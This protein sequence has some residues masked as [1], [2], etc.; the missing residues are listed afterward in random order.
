M[1]LSFTGQIAA[2]DVNI[3]LTFPGTNTITLND[4]AVRNLAA[5][6]L[7]PF[8]ASTV[9]ANIIFFANTCSFSGASAIDANNKLLVWGSYFGINEPR[10]T[11][12]SPIQIGN[13]NW[14]KIQMAYHTSYMGIKSDGTLWAWGD[15][16]N[17]RLGLNTG[18]TFSSPVQVGTKNTWTDVVGNYDGF[19]L[20]ESSNTVYGTGII[21]DFTSGTVHRSSPVFLGYANT[22]FINGGHRG[23]SGAYEL[24]EYDSDGL[25]KQTLKSDESTSFA[26][27]RAG[28]A[29]FTNWLLNDCRGNTHSLLVKKQDDQ[30]RAFIYGTGGDGQLGNSSVFSTTTGLRTNIEYVPSYDG[31]ACY[32]VGYDHTL[33]Q[34]IVL[35]TRTAGNVALYVTGNNNFGQLGTNSTANSNSFVNVGT[36]TA[37]TTSTGKILTRYKK[38]TAGNKTSFGIL[39]GDGFQNYDDGKLFAWGLNNYGQLGSNNTVNYSSPVQI[40]TDRWKTITTY[41]ESSAAIKVDGSLWTF[42]RNN[43]G[44]LGINDTVDYSSPVQIGTY[45]W[46]KVKAG[47]DFFIAKK[48]NGTLWVWGNNSKGQLGLNDTVNR[49]SPVQLS[50]ANSVIDF[51]ATKDAIAYIIAA[52]VEISRA[53][54]ELYACGGND[55]GQLGEND[56]VYRSSPTLVGS[57]SRFLKLYNANYD[58]G[59]YCLLRAGGS[60]QPNTFY[61]T[62]LYAWGNNNQNQLGNYKDFNYVTNSSRSSPTFI[63]NLRMKK[64]KEVPLESIRT[65]AQALRY[66]DEHDF[67]WFKQEELGLLP[68]STHSGALLFPTVGSSRK[69]SYGNWKK[70][71]THAYFSLA[72]D[73]WGNLFGSGYNYNGVLTTEYGA[74]NTLRSQPCQIGPA[75]TTRTWSDIQVDKHIDGPRAFALTNEG[76]LYTWG[77]NTHG[78]LGINS[79]V[80]RSNPTLVGNTS[81]RWLKAVPGTTSAG[82][83]TDGTLWTWAYNGSGTLGLN[84]LVHRSS[85]VQIGSNTWIDI[86]VANQTALGLAQQHMLGVQSNGT[87]WSWGYGF[88]GA[89]GTNDI[90]NRSSPVQIG[91]DTNWW[92][93]FS[94]GLSSY[95]TKI[96]GTLWAWGYNTESQLGIGVV[97]HRSSPVQIGFS[98]TDK[99]IDLSSSLIGCHAI[100]QSG[101][102]WVW[103]TNYNTFLNPYAAANIVYS[104]PVLISTGSDPNNVKNAAFIDSGISGSATSNAFLIDNSGT[105]F[106]WGYNAYGAL[107]D[108][109][110]LTTKTIG[111]VLFTKYFLTDGQMFV[112]HS[113][114]LDTHLK[115][116]INEWQDGVQDFTTYYP[117]FSTSS[118]ASFYVLLNG[119]NITP[120][121]GIERFLYWG[122]SLKNATSVLPSVSRSSPVVV[123]SGAGTKNILQIEGQVVGITDT[124][125]VHFVRS[126]NSGGAGILEAWGDGTS[127]N[128][129]NFDFT[130]RS[131]PVSVS[132][133]TTVL[134]SGAFQIPAFRTNQSVISMDDLRGRGSR[135]VQV[136]L[137]I[138]AGTFNGTP[139]GVPG[140]WIGYDL[141]TNRGPKYDA[142]NTEITLTVEKGQ[143][144]GTGAVGI[145]DG[146]ITVPS[147]FHPKDKIKIVNYGYIVGQ[148]GTGGNPSPGVTADR[149]G[150]PGRGALL[151]QRPVIIDNQGTIAGGGG[152]GG[153]G[154]PYPFV[155]PRPAKQGGPLTQT[156][157]GGGGGGGAG[158]VAGAGSGFPAATPGTLT[159]GG[160]GIPGPQTSPTSPANNGGPGGSLG[161]A[162]SFA[163]PTGGIGGS[164]GYYIQGLPFVYWANTGTRLGPSS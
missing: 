41:N 100:T 34:G 156:L 23:E 17:G 85:P 160:A 4:T 115:I 162:G 144:V 62:D 28:G 141:Y 35:S 96:D 70:V 143:I 149:L 154:S 90:V 129:G 19:I 131:S 164:A 142:G 12:V 14:S 73:N 103:G 24:I 50:V 88:H 76:N 44:Q 61:Y 104:S 54:T 101:N 106:A 150:I 125:S 99:V 65:S 69:N 6:P 136:Q 110:A 42:G 89:L 137:T 161:N 45:G 47:L 52:N 108:N 91:T 27:K 66:I 87:L 159:I 112:N 30:G 102:V 139:T 31:D 114:Y 43:N 117:F 25:I 127:G 119:T 86:A 157:S 98:A 80:T 158:S 40:G 29:L 97:G 147:A 138:P 72:I 130:S 18:T 124:G 83:R 140:P 109:T 148:G 60:F 78:N 113:G 59:F 126:T 81:T 55:Y 93:V 135:A 95:A 58:G 79:I 53:N 82:I 3:E 153:G 2:N 111:N 11:S 33:I 146:A 32:A 13:D 132:A 38:L 74:V 128:L 63:G 133:W 134:T 122:G 36:T 57:D 16:Q 15:N 68:L 123:A 152:G 71:A 75:N 118:Q 21:T 37:V 107:A 46:S 105:A 163:V 155:T 116:A 20:I 94:R 8:P 7:D 5:I 121:T 56:L 39:S 48:E 92:K 10:K 77:I 49:S 64:I 22:G 84:D 1:A 67:V 9:T 145:F 26:F 151:I 51:A 120:T